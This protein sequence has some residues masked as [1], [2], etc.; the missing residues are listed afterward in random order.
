MTCCALRFL[1]LLVLSA[2]E[3]AGRVNGAVVVLTRGSADQL[4]LLA[5]A[6]R[7]ADAAFNNRLQ[8]PYVVFYGVSFG[9]ARSELPTQEQLDWL[10]R[11]TTS[12][13]LFAEVN[14]TDYY[15][16]APHAASSPEKVHGFRRG[17]R[18]MCRFYAGMIADH[19][20]LQVRRCRGLPRSTVRPASLT[21]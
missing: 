11:N 10:S 18:D 15:W 5:R 21:L 4:E 9:E 1:I 20:A 7:S 8:Y 12:R 17:Y 14:L 3:A 13:L 16:S 2:H 19:P 6:I